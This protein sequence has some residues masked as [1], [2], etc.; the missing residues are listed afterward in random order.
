MFSQC[1]RC[2]SWGTLLRKTSKTN[3]FLIPH[4]FKTCSPEGS[5]RGTNTK[6]YACLCWGRSCTPCVLTCFPRPNAIKNPM[7]AYAGGGHA[8]HVIL[9]C[10]PYACLCCWM[11]AIF[12][13][14]SR[15]RQIQQISANT[16]RYVYKPYACSMPFTASSYRQIRVYTGRYR[17]KPAYI[18]SKR[19][20][21]MPADIFTNPM[22]AYA[23]D[24]Q[25]IQ[26]DTNRYRQ[27]PTDTRRILNCWSASPWSRFPF[28][29]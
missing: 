5:Y 19:Y 26:A 27:I 1:K 9:R 24:C 25:A 22:L 29:C 21:K 23:F 10:K 15:Y 12:A 14:T 11:S 16:G 17:Q 8:L 2:S 6:P 4:V 13:A 28:T 20:Q 3:V 18:E 7:L